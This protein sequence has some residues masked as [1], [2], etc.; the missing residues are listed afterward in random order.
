MAGWVA[1][2]IEP[3]F[4]FIEENIATLQEKISAPYLGSIPWF[5][6]IEN[7]E[8]NQLDLTSLRDTSYLI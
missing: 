4:N 8:Q 7:L 2:M 5:A 3:E 1:N 6:E